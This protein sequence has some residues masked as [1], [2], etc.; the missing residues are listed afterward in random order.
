MTSINAAI[1]TSR[2]P[3]NEQFPEINLARHCGIPVYTANTG[4]E[5]GSDNLDVRDINIDLPPLFGKRLQDLIER[6]HYSFWKPPA[7][8]D[9]IIY[10]TLRT[11]SPVFWPDQ[12]HVHYFHGIH[13]GSFDLPA[14]DQYS[15]NSFLK[16]FQLLNRIRIRGLNAN[17][18]NP[19]DTIVANSKFTSEM[20]KILYNVEI[21]K[22]IHPSFVDVDL[23]G[24][25]VENRNDYYL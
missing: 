23:Y 3:S 1:V 13:R 6:L 17:S 10:S 9:I 22:I 14:R 25:K 16:T 20:I 15:N 7:Q 18:F 12:H 5:P 4:S 24:D 19:I 11:Q 21:D 8:Y 2:K